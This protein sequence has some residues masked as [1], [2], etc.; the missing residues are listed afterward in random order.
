V[1]SS[2][3]RLAIPPPRRRSLVARL[4]WVLSVLLMGPLIAIGALGYLALSELGTL[5]ARRE[6]LAA[7]LGDARQASEEVVKSSLLDRV[8]SVSATEGVEVLDVGALFD[9]VRARVTP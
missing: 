4:Q 5:N 6:H 1:S 8:L 2:G 7:A 3:T 9:A